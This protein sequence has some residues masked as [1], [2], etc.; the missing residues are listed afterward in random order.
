MRIAASDDDRR[1]LESFGESLRF[2]LIV[3]AVEFGETG[4]GAVAAEAVAGMSVEVLRADGAKCAR[5]WHYTTDVGSDGEFPE[6][7]GRCAGNVRAILAVG[8]P[9]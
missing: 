6:V 1:F 4:E 7:C 3:S 8:E 2:Y 5:C 9:G